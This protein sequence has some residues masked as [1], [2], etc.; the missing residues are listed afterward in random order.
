MVYKCLINKIKKKVQFYK[1][2]KQFY[3]T[4]QIGLDRL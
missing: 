2:K 4:F 3:K 1:K